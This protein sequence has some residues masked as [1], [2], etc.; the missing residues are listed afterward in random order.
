MRTRI[1][2]WG[3]GVAIAIPESLAADFGLSED[4]WIELRPRSGRLEIV[5]VSSESSDLTRMLARVT[6]ENL[7]HEADTG[8]S[9]G[10]EAW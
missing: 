3:D 9:V 4:L 1:Q 8:A 10:N 5:P 2:K 7:H 6:D